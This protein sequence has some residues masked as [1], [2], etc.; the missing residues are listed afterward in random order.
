MQF[1]DRLNLGQTYAIRELF[2]LLPRPDIIS[3]AGGFPDTSLFDVE[4]IQ[5]ASTRALHLP[6]ALHRFCH[7]V[8]P[9]VGLLTHDGKLGQLSRHSTPR[10]NAWV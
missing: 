3:F 9:Y 4:G 7:D 5:D 8:N 10:L 2:K 1:S 6:P